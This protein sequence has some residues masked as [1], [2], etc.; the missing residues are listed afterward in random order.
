[1]SFEVTP[2]FCP[3]CK[4]MP[5]SSAGQTPGTRL[6]QQCQSMVLSA[7]R[8][9]ISNR[10]SIAVAGQNQAIAEVYSD[11]AVNECSMIAAAEFGVDTSSELSLPAEN[12][13]IPEFNQFETHEDSSFRFFA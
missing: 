1:M 13:N 12:P 6:C 5:G 4:R 9:S 3:L 8:G 2:L 10:D 11:P 7:F